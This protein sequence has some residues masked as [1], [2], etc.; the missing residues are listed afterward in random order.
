MCA[1]ESIDESEPSPH[2]EKLLEAANDASQTVAA[3]HVAFMAFAAY[4]GVILWGTTHEDLL[5]DSKIKLPILDVEIPLTA[6]YLFVPWLVILLH[7]NLLMQLELLSRKL[8]NLDRKI[9]PMQ[10]Q[11][12]QQMRDRLFIFPFTHLIAGRS[13]VIIIR[14]LLSLVVGLTVIAL[15]LAMLMAAQIRFLPY[16]DENITW[17][18]RGAVWTDVMMLLILWPLIVS[19]NDSGRESWSHLKSRLLV[20][21]SFIKFLIINYLIIKFWNLLRRLLPNLYLTSFVPLDMPHAG[22]EAKGMFVL[23]ISV[24]IV[25]P[26]SVVVVIP[27]SITVQTYYSHSKDTTHYFEDWLIQHGFFEF[28]LSTP[29]PN[30]NDKCT[31]LPLTHELKGASR[32]MIGIPCSWLNSDSITRD[33]NLSETHLIPK[34][35]SYS[36]LNNAIATDKSIHIKAFK[37]FDGLHLES[38]DL[39]FADLHSAVLPQAHLNGASLKGASLKGAQLQGANLDKAHLEGSDLSEAQ[40]QEAHLEYAHLEGSDLSGS[41]LQRAILDNAHIEHST[42]P[43]AQLQEAHL[44]YAHLEGSDLSGSILQRAILD[45]ALMEG[46]ILSKAQLQGA[47]L[48]VTHLNGAQLSNAHLQGADLSS[49]QL[50]GANLK[51]VELQSANLSTAELRGADLTRANL[52]GANLSSTFLHGAILSDAYLQG[53]YMSGA[54]LSGS[55]WLNTTLDGILIDKFLT[56]PL[57]EV[58][59]SKLEKDLEPL[60]KKDEFNAFKG[61][62]DRLNIVGEPSSQVGCLSTMISPL[63]KNVGNSTLTKVAYP[64]LVKLA[65][66]D[67]VI[68]EGIVTNRVVNAASNGIGL[69]DALLKALK[70]KPCIGL[71]T[72]SEEIQQN[73]RK[74]AEPKNNLHSN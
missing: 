6:F 5:R 73:L 25:L 27:G 28:L 70:T 24:L 34:E 43:K 61:R 37:E 60:L 13:N 7:F 18:Q 55:D 30:N 45:N 65:C 50:N 47:H 48:N 58:D 26:I 9:T 66:N 52:Q 59:K 29:N 19:I 8:W 3:L 17:W 23:L 32:V 62:L 41:Q 16:H 69:A 38:R 1:P 63:C 42:L 2:I 67:A 10:T 51:N 20:F 14:W 33:L 39:R 64:L 56:E 15:P 72:L 40:L 35:V 31:S 11:T 54:T 49:V 36:L 12:G 74:I 21:F 46:S 53:A 71:S 4:Y 44:K 68:A 22:T 57:N